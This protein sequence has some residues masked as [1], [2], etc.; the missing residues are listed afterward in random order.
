MTVS[1]GDVVLVDFPFAS[2]Q[3][4]KVRPALVVQ[5][6]RNNSRLH[7]TIVAQITSR[8]QYAHREPTQVLVNIS[9][10]AGRQ[11]GLLRDSAVAC[12]NL[13]TIRVDA[14][15]RKIG[16]MPADVMQQVSECLKASLELA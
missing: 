13:Y 3:G 9:S 15:V 7:N 16:T 1:R 2:G 5:C 12:E 10:A 11:S 4:S 8:T 14:V 6:N